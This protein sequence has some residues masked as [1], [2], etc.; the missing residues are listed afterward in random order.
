MLGHFNLI[1][2]APPL[3]TARLNP[4]LFS[5]M[6]Q[7]IDVGQCLFPQLSYALALLAF[8]FSLPPAGGRYAPADVFPSLWL[9]DSK[10]LR[11]T[12]GP[13][14]SPHCSSSMHLCPTFLFSLWVLPVCFARIFFKVINVGE[15]WIDG[16]LTLQGGEVLY[17]CFSCEGF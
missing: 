10:L 3:W 5:M 4:M 6:F 16:A 15:C 2:Y 8:S 17:D 11:Q 12:V 14:L 9:A 7:C 13:P 1:I